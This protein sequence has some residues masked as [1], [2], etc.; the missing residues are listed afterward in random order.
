MEGPKVPA[1]Y[2]AEY[3]LVW[4]QWEERTIVLSRIDAP[5]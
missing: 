2:V 3:G 5:V 1:A 4:Y